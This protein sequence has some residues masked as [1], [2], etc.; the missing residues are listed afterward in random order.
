VKLKKPADFTGRSVLEEQRRTGLRRKL[1]G[2]NIRD[3]AIPRAGYAILHDGE[4][5]GKVTSGTMSP[6]LE[7]PIALGYVP[8][9][10]ATPG[11]SIAID[12]RG[13]SVEAEVAALPFY[14]R[15]LSPV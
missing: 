9:D 6:T 5:V 3:R 11:T 13:R 10:L 14:K 2:L 15:E 4:R 8:P 12:I 7:R 1:V